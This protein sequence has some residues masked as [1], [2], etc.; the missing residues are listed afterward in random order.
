MSNFS[1]FIGKAF[2]IGGILNMPYSSDL[3]TAADGTQWYA[4]VSTAPFDYTS[5]YS[6]LPDHLTSPHPIFYGPESGG[7]WYGPVVSQSIS[8]AYNPSGPLYVTATFNGNA[9]NGFK[10]Y[11]STNGS[12]WTERTF[13][14]S[15][16]YPIIQY[17]AGKFIAVSPSSTTDG[18]ITS[19]DGINWTS[20]TGVS[21]AN[22]TDIISDGTDVI[23]FPYNSTTAAY[24]SDGGSTWAS[25]TMA[26][27]SGTS[28]AINTNG[29]GSITWNAGAGLFIAITS[30]TGQYQTSATGANGSWTART[31]AT[32]NGYAQFTNSTRFASNSTTTVA[33]G[34]TGFFATT[35][36]GLTWSNHGLISTSLATTSAPLAVYHDGTRFV[37]RFSQRVFYSTDGVTWT[38][39]KPIGGVSI[40][41]PVS[42]GVMFSFL[43]NNFTLI[44]KMLKISDVTLTT[45][46]TIIPAAGHSFF[47]ATVNYV[48]IR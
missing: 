19:T 5:D 37:V 13:P 15:K 2:P 1:Q 4:L 6:Y 47:A 10:Y 28:N 20:V 43:T 16:T 3:Y 44:N 25:S 17:T 29:I 38:E 41:S 11:T 46:Q 7:L 14:N 48:R 18:I 34:I 23:V 33:V 36:D 9:T 26:A 45:P 24:S 12:T 30:T 32:Y 8:I 22:I 27:S 40:N 31:P 42:S 39:G 35:T 21:I